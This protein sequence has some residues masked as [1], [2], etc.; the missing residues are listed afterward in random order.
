MRLATFNIRRGRGFDGINTWWLRRR[1]TADTIRYLDVDVIGLQEVFEEQRRYLARRVTGSRWY[2]QGRSGGRRGEQC[3]VVVLDPGLAV[4]DSRTMWFGPDPDVAGTRLPGASFPRVA[5]IVRCR[6]GADGRQFVVANTH[7]D[8][9]LHENRVASVRQLAAT[10]DRDVPTVV[11]GDLNATQDDVE[12][13]A[14]L[15]DAGFRRAPLSGSTHHE[16]KGTVEG[17]Q[18][19]HVFLSR[20]WSIDD[21]DVVRTKRGPLLPSDHWPVR[22]VVRC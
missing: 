15:V 18:I 3:P 10:L 1:L 20:H 21:S 22:A 12:V 14:P 16:F 13:L 9:H 8:E 11:L 17:T 6:A 2:G 19:D 7:L 4:V 5:T